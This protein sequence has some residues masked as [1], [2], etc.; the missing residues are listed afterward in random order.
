MPNIAEG[1][2]LSDVLKYE[3]P[4]LFSR[5]EVVVASGQNLALGAVVGRVTASGKIVAL[6]PDA[7]DGSQTALGIVI[8][9][10]DASAVDTKSVIITRH[11]ILSD[12]YVV[13]PDGI[14]GPQQ[15]TATAQLEARGVLIRK[16]A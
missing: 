15:S 11:A 2:Y 7:S 4:N 3:A 1:N 5:E 16:G 6:D 9:D 10:V 14:T 8:R 12:K 13:W